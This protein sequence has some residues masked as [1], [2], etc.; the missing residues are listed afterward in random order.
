MLSLG[1]QEKETRDYADKLLLPGKINSVCSNTA[2][3]QQCT[4]VCSATD[5]A[6]GCITEV[7]CPGED[8]GGCVFEK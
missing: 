4:E 6:N 1:A 7:R 2:Y 8:Y 5:K 3:V